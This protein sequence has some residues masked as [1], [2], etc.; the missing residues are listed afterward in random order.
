[1]LLILLAAGV[2]PPAATGAVALLRLDEIPG[3]AGIKGYEGWIELRAYGWGGRQTSD[4]ALLGPLRLAKSLDAATPR[5][6][7][8][9]ATGDVVDEGEMVFLK[10]GNGS[11]PATP[12]LK[13]ELSDIF[14]TSIQFPPSPDHLEQ[15]EIEF[16]EA[17]FSYPLA[18]YETLVLSLNRV[19]NSAS[20]ELIVPEP[21]IA[22]IP[23]QEMTSGSSL[24]VHLWLDDPVV[25]LDEL[26]VTAF[27]GDATLVPSGGLVLAGGGGQRSLSI[28]PAAGETGTTGITV[29][30]HNGFNSASTGFQ[31]TVLAPAPPAAVHLDNDQL[32]LPGHPGD[33]VGRLVVDGGEPGA[34]HSFDLADSAEDRF[35]L[36]DD[37][38][39]VGPNPD[40]DPAVAD[41]HTVVIGVTDGFGHR[42]EGT[43]TVFL[44]QA[45]QAPVLEYG[46][47]DPVLT[48]AFDEV[49]VA[50]LS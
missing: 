43:L 31:L 35:V 21:V 23:D 16:G 49:A 2:A 50:G 14:L 6:L 48:F 17:V 11:E 33:L 36:D 8:R 29:S 4:R 25:P 20:L 39:V 34:T 27:A 30:V 12:F 9:L 32:T 40:F 45:N 15:F 22:A 24:A 18:T 13:V 5:L 26:T 42:I 37:R 46:G 19:K 38:L 47:T 10:S 41:R 1:M 3:E 28:T 7:H 44:A